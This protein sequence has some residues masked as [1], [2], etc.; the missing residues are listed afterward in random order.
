MIYTVFY[1]NKEPISFR[2]NASHVFCDIVNE[3]NQHAAEA[4]FIQTFP[5]RRITRVIEGDHVFDEVARISLL[6]NHKGMREEPVQ[7][8]T[9]VLSEKYPVPP[10]LQYGLDEFKKRP[11]QNYRVPTPVLPEDEQ[12]GVVDTPGDMETMS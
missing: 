12:V 8:R 3:E 2:L 7:N 10:G 4:Y 11:Q 1:V 5:G 6:Y 9:W